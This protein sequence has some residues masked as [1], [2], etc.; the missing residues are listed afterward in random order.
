MHTRRV[1]NRYGSAYPCSF[2][3]RYQIN[4]GAKSKKGRLDGVTWVS[5]GPFISVGNVSE[6]RSSGMM[7]MLTSLRYFLDTAVSKH[8]FVVPSR[9]EGQVPG[10]QH[11]LLRCVRTDHRGHAVERGGHNDELSG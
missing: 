10:L 3:R 2:E 6:L 1:N 4:Y 5:D 8:C 11:V 7:P 9:E